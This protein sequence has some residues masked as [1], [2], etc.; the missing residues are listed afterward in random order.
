MRKAVFFDRDGTLNNNQDHYYIW[1]P[2]NFQLNPGVVETLLELKRRDYMLIV[3]TNQG[4]I[5][6]EEYTMDD[7]E[8]LH[9]HL[10]ALLE[11]E[12]IVLASEIGVVLLL[13]AI[14][15]TVA[16]SKLKR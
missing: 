1:E 14:G 15:I 12:G 13:V 7:V 4:G 10:C 11:Q 8:Y 2:G 5:A 9:D 6:K 3:V 16:A